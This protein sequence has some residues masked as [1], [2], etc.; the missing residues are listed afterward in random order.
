MGVTVLRR[1]RINK[2]VLIRMR[3]SMYGKFSHLKFEIL[4][5]LRRGNDWKKIVRYSGFCSFSYILTGSSPFLPS[6]QK[7]CRNCILFLVGYI[8]RLLVARMHVRLRIKY[9]SSTSDDKRDQIMW[10]TAFAFFPLSLSLWGVGTTGWE[11]SV[12][13]VLTKHAN[14]WIRAAKGF[15]S[16]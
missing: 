2:L 13:S 6:G 15:Y 3:S 10:G 11:G 14:L 7:H 9:C 4:N 16:T 12:W 1:P 5:D 8:C